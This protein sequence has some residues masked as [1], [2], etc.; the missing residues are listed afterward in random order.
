MDDDED[1]VLCK[2][3]GQ[4]KYERPR[5]G[6]HFDE[7]VQYRCIDDNVE[8]EEHEQ[9]S[10]VDRLDGEEVAECS[11]VLVHAVPDQRHSPVSTLGQHQFYLAQ[12]AQSNF[13][14]KR[15][16]G[17]YEESAFEQGIDKEKTKQPQGCTANVTASSC[18]PALLHRTSGPNSEIDLSDKSSARYDCKNQDQF[19][20]EKCPY[21]P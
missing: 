19:T 8:E 1:K 13:V 15:K 21:S 4:P 11:D 16:L 2:H 14:Y 17:E 3:E 20:F 9:Y 12:P 5:N 6:V 7:Q 18:Q 10:T